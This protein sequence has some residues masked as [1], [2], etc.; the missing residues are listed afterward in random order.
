MNLEL[1]TDIR[2]NYPDIKIIGEIKPA[3]PYEPRFATAQEK[4]KENFDLLHSI[5]PHVDILSIHTDPLWWGSYDWLREAKA[6]VGDKKVLAKGF[7]PSM[8]HVEECRRCGADYV[9]TFGWHP[10]QDHQYCWHE[11]RK[12]ENSESSVLVFNSRNPRTGELRNNHYRE[13]EWFNTNHPEL[14]LVQASNIKTVDDIHSD[15][16]YVLIGTALCKN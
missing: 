8:P 9:L 6:I 4:Y 1:I 14:Q 5:A 12:N 15:V 10:G 2:K 7:H 13:I 11:M 16:Q 3:S